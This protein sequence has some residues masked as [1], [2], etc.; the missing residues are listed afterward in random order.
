M[1]LSYFGPGV[2]HSLVLCFHLTFIIVVFQY[3]LPQFY[4]VYS[5]YFIIPYLTLSVSCAK[6]I[7]PV[8]AIRND[9]VAVTLCENLL[10]FHF[11]P[12]L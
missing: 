6:R 1:L 12:V 5:F 4:N 2:F 7:K 10:L 11:I 3:S 8:L 9:T